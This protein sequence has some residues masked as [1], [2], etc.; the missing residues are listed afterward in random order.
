MKLLDRVL[1]ITATLFGIGA[2]VFALR[3]VGDPRNAY[4]GWV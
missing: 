2:F 3:S 4:P 1:C